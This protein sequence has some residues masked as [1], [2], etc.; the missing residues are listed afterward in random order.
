M[1]DADNLLVRRRFRLT[2]RI[3]GEIVP[4]GN[5]R[6]LYAVSE[7]GLLYL[8][9][10]DLEQMPQLEVNPADRDLFFQF[11]FCAREADSPTIRLEKPDRRQ[12]GPLLPLESTRSRSSL[13][14]CCLSRIRA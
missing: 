4:G 5:G 9:L 1:M 3:V 10:E 6:Y 14:A 11:D 8:P 7:G 13:R 2:E 12:A